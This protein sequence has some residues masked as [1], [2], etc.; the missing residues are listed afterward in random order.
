[1]H[2][3]KDIKNFEQ[4]MT[5]PK[6]K[7]RF[8]DILNEGRK[9]GEKL[10]SSEVWRIIRENNP[11]YTTN[12]EAQKEEIKI[13]EIHDK[14]EKDGKKVDGKVDKKDDAKGGKKGKKK[15]KKCTDD[16]FAE[17][18]FYR[19]DDSGDIRSKFYK[20]LPFLYLYCCRCFQICTVY[21]T[22]VHVKF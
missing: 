19:D 22:R 15:S 8:M 10:N 13:E 11:N 16:A 12:S 1:M 7:A 20:A 18:S 4:E 5:G 2:F 21:F 9:S 17:D 6:A 14:E 3:A